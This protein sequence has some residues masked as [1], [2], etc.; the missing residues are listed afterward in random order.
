MVA[1]SEYK[2]LVVAPIPVRRHQPSD[3]WALTSLRSPEVT[4][5]GTTLVQDWYN[6]GTNEPV[7]KAV[8][9]PGRHG[10]RSVTQ[11]ARS[12]DTEDTEQRASSTCPWLLH[13]FGRER[14]EKEF[15]AFF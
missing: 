13:L 7:R 15:F 5:S 9:L 3:A 14:A 2:S 12:A 10:F 1:A 11:R 6:T 4:R 8:G